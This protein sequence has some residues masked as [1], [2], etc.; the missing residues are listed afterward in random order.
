MYCSEVLN[1]VFLK[2]NKK[3]KKQNKKEFYGMFEPRNSWQHL[4][5]SFLIPMQRLQLYIK[6][7]VDVGQGR[8]TSLQILRHSS[9]GTTPATQLCDSAKKEK[10]KPLMHAMPLYRPRD[11]RIRSFP[12]SRQPPPICFTW[13][14]RGHFTRSS[15]FLPQG[16]SGARNFS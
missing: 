7:E 8:S 6:H 10:Q 15:N 1:K 4:N 5:R 2:K 12:Y 13:G 14:R 16:E 9:P 3:K 11:Y